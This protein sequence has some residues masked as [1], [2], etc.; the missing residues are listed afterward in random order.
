MSTPLNLL[1]QQIRD[2]KVAQFVPPLRIP[3]GQMVVGQ[4]YNYKL[5]GL[6]STLWIPPIIVTAGA[7][8]AQL[9]TVQL[10]VRI[11]KQGAPLLAWGLQGNFIS[12]FSGPVEEIF[13]SLLGGVPNADYYFYG[14][15]GIGLG[16]SGALTAAGTPSSSPSFGNGA[17]Q[18][19]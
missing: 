6:C 5:G 18:Q 1:M 16:Y 15:R 11:N 8:V 3:L 13:V 14:A 12:S 2:G 19:S 17:P 10:G 9:A 4:E 7:P